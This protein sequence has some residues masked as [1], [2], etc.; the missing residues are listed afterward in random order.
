MNKLILIILLISSVCYSQRPSV[1]TNN[2]NYAG[3]VYYVSSAG[4]SYNSGLSKSKTWSMVK[5]STFK[6]KNNDTI[7]FKGGDTI[8]GTASFTHLN[9][10]K[11]VL[12]SYGTG[13]AVIKYTGSIQNMFLV[14][15]DSTIKIEF[16]NLV[17]LGGYN[18]VNQTGGATNARAIYIYNTTSDTKGGINSVVID[19]CDFKNFW[20]TAIMLNIGSYYKRGDYLITHNTFDSLGVS[21]LSGS[22]ICYSNFQIVGNKFTNILS[23]TGEIYGGTGGFSYCR[24]AKVERNYVNNIGQYCS[25]GAVGLYFNSSR[26]IEFRYNEV[27]NIKRVT[28]EGNGLYVDC[29]SDSCLFEYNYLQNCQGYGIVLAN[30]PTSFCGLYG[31]TGFVEDSL[32]SSFNIARFNIIIQDSG[33]AGGINMYA[34]YGGNTNFQK[35]NMIYNNLIAMKKGRRYEGDTAYYLPTGI[36]QFGRS[37]SLY[38]YNNIFYLDS[39][40]AIRHDS[41]VY[42]IN[43]F[44]NHN[45]YYQTDGLNNHIAERKLNTY[46]VTPFYWYYRRFVSINNW[47]DTTGF[48]QS[49]GYVYVNSNPLIVN[50][51]MRVYGASYFNPYFLDTLTSY[52][53]TSGSPAK[54]AGVSYNTQVIRIADTCTVDFYGNAIPYTN[55]DIGVFEQ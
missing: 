23:R 40:I 49:G 8:I 14:P 54:N 51:A 26:N 28:G 31:P 45:L 42:F 2:Y 16:N 22:G 5:L 9:N 30:A 46:N 41:T 32:E 55:K 4:S 44:I 38:I 35:R 34:G 20:S 47:A 33:A 13:K 53:V 21:A 7:R 12:N 15:F 43:A 39:A 10:R 27:R 50:F 36:Q 24:N 18:A 11:V 6:F 19:S 48:E 52:K 3:S 17:F 25:I 37:D 29:G 1:L